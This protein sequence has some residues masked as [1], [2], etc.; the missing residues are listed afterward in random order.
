MAFQVFTVWP[1]DAKTDLPGA[2]GEAFFSSIKFENK[3]IT[4]FHRACMLSHR[5]H[6]RVMQSDCSVMAQGKG[7]TSARGTGSWLA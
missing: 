1:E 3:H 7:R 6:L 5:K 4:G 2:E